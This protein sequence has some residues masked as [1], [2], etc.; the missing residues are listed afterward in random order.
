MMP[1]WLVFRNQKAAYGQHSIPG[2]DTVHLCFCQ[3]HADTGNAIVYGC[4]RCLDELVRLPP[5]ANAMPAL[6]RPGIMLTGMPVDDAE[7]EIMSVIRP[8]QRKK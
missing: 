2:S 4:S 7:R 6:T 3:C 5:F 8:R 1:D